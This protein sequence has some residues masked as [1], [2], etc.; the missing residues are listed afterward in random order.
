MSDA[1]FFAFLSA[2][3]AE[4]LDKQPRFDKRI[5]GA[6]TWHYD[7]DD[8]TLRLGDSVF[9]ITAIGSHSPERQTWLWAWAN[10]GFP[11]GART[12]S[13]GLQDLYHVTGFRVFIDPGI[14]A[15]PADAQDFTALA[16]HQLDAVGFFR[17]PA[18]VRRGRR[19][20]SPCTNSPRL[21]LRFRK[22]VITER[23]PADR[24][25]DRSA[26]GGSSDRACAAAGGPSRRR[27]APRWWARRPGPG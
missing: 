22:L 3:R 1:K 15:W 10:E 13:R 25:R 2:C 18:E 7:L 23:S 21:R 26:G 11:A 6:K 4:L 16:V 19:C 20:I 8:N 9:P 27:A 14:P 24:R 5:A 17:A 12:A